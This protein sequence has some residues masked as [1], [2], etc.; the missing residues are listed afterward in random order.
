MGLILIACAI[1][2]IVLGVKGFTAS[3]I[4][5][6]RSK[7]LKGR[8]GKILGVICIASGILL[9]PAFWLFFMLI[10]WLF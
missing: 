4:R 6:S 8:N 7:T 2:L 1:G 5:V 3:G 10:M 9:L